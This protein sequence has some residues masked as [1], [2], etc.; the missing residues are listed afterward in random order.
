MKILHTADWHIGKILHKYS[1]STELDLFFDWMINYIVDEDIDLLIVSGDI[2]DLANPTIRDKEQYYDIVLRLYNTGCKVIFTGGN[3]DSV[4]ELNAPKEILSAIN[5]TV[6]GGATETI[7]DEL[8]PVKNEKGDIELIV[9]AVPFLRD[10]DLRTQEDGIKY[11]SRVEAIREGIKAHYASLGDICS[12]EYPHTMALAMG[13]LYASGVTVSESE[14][15]IHVGNQAAVRSNIFPEQFKY[16]ALGHIHKPQIVDSNPRIRY[17]GS[18]IALS[19][20]EKA[21]T[22]QVILIETHQG[23]VTEVTDIAVPQSRELKKI[24]GTLEEIEK[25]LKLYE[26]DYTLPS[27]VEVEVTEKEFSSITLAAVEELVLSYS[28]SDKFK[29]LKHKTVFENKQLDTA[30]LFTEGTS[31]EELKPIDVFQKRL[32]SEDI[33]EASRKVV[34]EAFLEL[35]ESL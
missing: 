7:A 10:R 24:T 29:I 27:F 31:I 4:G 8:I 12:K 16:V 15:E 19:F 11:D 1:L 33:D 32:D 25:E 22:K 6:V 26:P 35:L 13:H 3:H 28:D 17:S 23:E 2:F 21:D 18:P 9:A 14:R 34:E 5:I 30:H 20:S